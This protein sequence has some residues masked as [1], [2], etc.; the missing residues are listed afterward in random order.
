MSTGPGTCP[1]FVSILAALEHTNSTSTPPGFAGSTTF[2]TVNKQRALLQL[3]L[4]I[5][6]SDTQ[7]S[8]SSAEDV[9]GTWL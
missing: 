1:V 4:Y 9:K 5:L 2:E 8:K 7:L 6:K 3:L